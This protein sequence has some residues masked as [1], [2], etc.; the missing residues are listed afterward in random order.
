M[1]RFC[2]GTPRGVLI[3]FFNLRTGR[4]PPPVRAVRCI[5]PASA[6]FYAG[7]GPPDNRPLP[8]FLPEV[9]HALCR[10]A[11]RHCPPVPAPRRAGRRRTPR[12]GPDRRRPGTL[13]V[14]SAAAADG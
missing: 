7:E 6:L 4:R 14:P 10:A 5:P 9:H 3:V 12:A 2:A 1:L 11:D 8:Y 13:G